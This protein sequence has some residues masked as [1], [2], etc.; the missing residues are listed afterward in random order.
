MHNDDRIRVPVDH[1]G[2]LED[3]E[4]GVQGGVTFEEADLGF[5]FHLHFRSDYLDFHYGTSP[6]LNCHQDAGKK[7]VK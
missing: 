5:L 3:L 4:N 1:S 2:N 7:N 6:S